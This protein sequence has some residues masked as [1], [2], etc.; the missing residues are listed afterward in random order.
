MPMPPLETARLLLRPLGPDDAE[1]VLCYRSD[2]EVARY[3]TW[4]P[5][6]LP[7]V[8]AFIARHTSGEPGDPGTWFQLGIV[9]AAAGELI[10]DC[11]LHAPA[12]RSH[13]AEVGVTI[14]P[15]HQGRGFATEALRAVVGYLFETLRMHRV[16]ASA[17]P[18]NVASLRLMDKL[19]MRREAHFRESLLIDGVWYDDVVCAILRREW[20]VHGA[21]PI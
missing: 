8:E 12:G 15:A 5:S 16:Y 1:A 19:G 9:L 11:G 17:D 7:E 14:A 10:G 2:P 21:Q 18:R 20:A 13:Q 3:Q 6:G 4:R